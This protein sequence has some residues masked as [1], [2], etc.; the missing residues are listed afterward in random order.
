M[1]V[2]LKWFFKFISDD[3]SVDCSEGGDGKENDNPKSAG[4]FALEINSIIPC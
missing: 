2:I 1:S 4:K 3:I